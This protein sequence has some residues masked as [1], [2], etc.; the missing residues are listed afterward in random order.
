MTERGYDDSALKAYKLAKQT[1]NMD[2]DLFVKVCT[3]YGDS[4]RNKDDQ[5]AYKIYKEAFDATPES[6]PQKI[7]L[8]NTL[9]Q[10]ER[11][12]AQLKPIKQTARKSRKIRSKVTCKCDCKSRFPSRLF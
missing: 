10:L 8:L 9:S 6:S 3:E 11:A 2:K 1:S 12:K 5:E 4:L 7:S